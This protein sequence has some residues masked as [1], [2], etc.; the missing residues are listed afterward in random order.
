MPVSFKIAEA[1]D[2]TFRAQFNSVQEGLRNIPAAIAYDRPTVT[3]SLNAFGSVFKGKLDPNR[4][5]IAGSWASTSGRTFPVALE[6][7]DPA[8]DTAR[9][10]SKSYEFS[11]PDDVR[12]HWKGTL[13]TKRN[14]SKVNLR[15]DLHLARMPDGSFTASLD[16][17]NELVKM[18]IEAST[19]QYSAPHFYAHWI[20]I[21]SEFDAHLQNGKISGTWK[22]DNGPHPLVLERSWQ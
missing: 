11:N 12:G 15:L 18:G 21:G 13:S 16:S 17:P 1:T 9:E 2:G 22:D 20:G 5:R 14:G 19:V 3:A 10:N 6:R 8:V 7:A 4:N